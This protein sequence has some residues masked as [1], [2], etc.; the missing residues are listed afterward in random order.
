VWV[1][2]FSPE[3]AGMTVEESVR[4]LQELVR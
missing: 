2:P 4:L 3:A 1:A